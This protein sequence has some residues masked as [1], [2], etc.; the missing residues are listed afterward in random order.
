MSSSSSVLSETSSA[1]D[2]QPTIAEACINY[3][4][5]ELLCPIT[6]E[7]P[8]DPVMAEDGRMYDRMAIEKAMNQHLR[9]QKVDGDNQGRLMLHAGNEEENN[10]ASLIGIRNN[11]GAMVR[12]PVTNEEMGT[13]LF[14]MIQVKN[15]IEQIVKSGAIADKNKSKIENWIEKIDTEK[16]VKETKKK[17]NSGDVEA[18][19]VLSRWYR[20]GLK[21]H[22]VDHS[23]SYNWCSRAADGG[24][25]I[26]MA[27]A[28][29]ALRSGIGI[30]KNII[31]GM[32]MLYLAA[33]QGSN[34]GAYFI[35][36]AYLE[37]DYGFPKDMLKA[38]RWLSKVVDDEGCQFK[39]LSKGH[40]TKAKEHLQE[41]EEEDP[42]E[43]TKKT[44]SLPKEKRNMKR[45]LS[46]CST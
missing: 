19:T 14:P 36:I 45:N 1:D 32:C 9:K 16:E 21:G 33:S 20:L 6:M 25:V 29:E 40:I 34:V 39:H 22:K 35:G 12:S 38:K 27:R 13:K 3:Q 17:A 5:D 18:M 7:L 24:H 28:G 2:G 15:I 42:F 41:L 23:K 31:E 30:Q 43:C 11:G 10:T 44:K 4:V 8:V 37:A 26:S 46:T